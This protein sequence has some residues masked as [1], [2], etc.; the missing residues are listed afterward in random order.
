MKKFLMI[1]GV[2]VY[3]NSGKVLEFKTGYSWA[4]HP[5]WNKAQGLSVLDKDKHEVNYIDTT[6]DD[7]WLVTT[8]APKVTKNVKAK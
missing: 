1:L 4:W 6:Y 8:E 2:F 7:V 5:G 3:F